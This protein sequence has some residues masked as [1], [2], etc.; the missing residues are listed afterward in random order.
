[1]AKTLLL[2]HGASNVVVQQGRSRK[3]RAPTSLPI[4]VIV[5]VEITRTLAKLLGA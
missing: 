2:L 4:K 5:R 1:M 3:L